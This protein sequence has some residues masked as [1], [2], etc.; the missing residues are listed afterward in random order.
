MLR[1]NDI[2]DRVLDYDPNAD[3]ELLQSAYVFSAKVHEGQERL[4][5][6]PY[7]VH[8]LEV[9]G[10]LVDMRLDDVT[11]AAGMLHDTVEDTLASLEE[12]DQ[13]FGEEVAFLVE[14]LTKISKVQFRSA[15]ARQA[16]NFRKMLVAMSKDI[17]I[18]LIKLADRIHNMRTLH[19]METDKAQGIAHETLDIYVPLAHRLGVNWMKRELEDLA[20]RILQPELCGELERMLRGRHA[21]RERYIEEV[22]GIVEGKLEEA[23]LSG[24]VTGRLKDLS[25]IHAKMTAQGLS[26]DQIYDVI[27]FRIVIEGEAE[28][29]YAALGLMHATWPPVPGRFKDYVALPKPNG[30]KSLHTTVIGP[31][32][33]RMELQIRTEEMHLHAELGIAAHWRYKGH[34][35]REQDDEQFNWLRQLLERQR[36][37]DDPHEFL[38]TVKVDLFRDEVFVFTPRGD[39]LNLPR[40]ST[41]L[42][43]AYGIHSEVG[44][45][46]SGARV[47]GTMRPLA[48]VLESGDTVE[49]LNNPNQAPKKDWLEFVVS[50]KAK[51]RIR[52]AVRL[53]E[54]ERSREL[55]RGILERELRKSGLSLNRLVESGELEPISGKLVK[56]GVEDLFAAVGYG[57]V[58]ARSVAEALRPELAEPVE[59]PEARGRKLRDLFRRERKTGS[60]I[61]VDGHGDVMVRFGQCCSPL[62]GD[63]IIGFVT[64]GRGVTVHN[65][66]C[67]VA[68][69]LDKDRCIEVEWE[70]ETDIKRRIR[71][72]VTSRDT[73][74][75]LAKVTKTISAAGINIGSAR[76]DTHDDRTATQTFDLWVSDVRTL[77][78]MMK[79]IQKIKGVQAVDRVR[80]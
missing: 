47:N 36:E 12:I 7:L 76:I 4:S 58:A 18:L 11:I 72:R 22:K 49:V 50:G 29:V 26:L 53:A 52:H 79:E 51:A 23:G 21:E 43:F 46:C 42:D 19:F 2:A 40:G 8:P 25:S 24:E 39:V 30:Y 75:L 35:G 67:R 65:R 61:R 60:G 78:A 62:P 31:Y 54:N 27:A 63:E 57:R 69:E 73:P 3:L 59:E 66:E 6:E 71:I 10:I 44:D 74:G 1:F 64:R 34:G 33:E 37:L 55:G 28:H 32:G 17:R 38:D 80:A 70:T 20:F 48:H 45:H 68:F 16:E 9:A 41:A 5:G 56:G 13:L 14:G 77:K 15:R